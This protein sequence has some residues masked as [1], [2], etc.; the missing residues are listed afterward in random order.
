VLEALREGAE[1]S[2]EEE[3]HEVRGFAL[4][5]LRSLLPSCSPALLNSQLER[6]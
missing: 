2:P 3:E 4:G 1:D 6:M 5:S